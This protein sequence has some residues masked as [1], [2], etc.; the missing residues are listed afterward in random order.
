MG[1][2]GGVCRK[3]NEGG[4]VFNKRIREELYSVMNGSMKIKSIKTRLKTYTMLVRL[5]LIKDKHESNH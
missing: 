2:Y 4:R 3:S 1:R 5:F